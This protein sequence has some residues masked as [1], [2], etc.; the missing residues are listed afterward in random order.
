M[1]ALQI[2]SLKNLMNQLLTGDTFD[3]FLLEEATI[4]TAV[5]YTIDGH[6]Y[7]DFYPME[8]RDTAA[9]YLLQ[10]WSE[11][12][13]LCFNLI[14]GRRTPLYFKFVF[15]LKPEKTTLLLERELP[16]TDH[17]PV[18]ALVLTLKYDAQGAVL[19]TGTSYH[20]FVLG[21]EIDALWDG[22]VRKYLSAR[23]IP[24]EL[25]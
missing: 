17:T 22:T 9:P 16:G 1:I 19:T 10:P 8:E 12:K 2:T 5:T 20:T 3:D 23:G 18:K 24:F 6:V 7:P 4:R 15:Q 14:K 11:T 21:R 25:L 13:G